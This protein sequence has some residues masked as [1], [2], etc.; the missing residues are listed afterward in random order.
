MK[1]NT[2]RICVIYYVFYCEHFDKKCKPAM[3][4]CN[5]DMRIDHHMKYSDMIPHIMLQRY[6][7]KENILGAKSGVCT[8]WKTAIVFPEYLTNIPW[9][10]TGKHQF[11]YKEDILCVLDIRR[12]LNELENYRE[13]ISFF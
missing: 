11:N 5:W 2:A 6:V 7:M 12:K 4:H 13:K 10:L 1:I 9:V 8:A 3:E